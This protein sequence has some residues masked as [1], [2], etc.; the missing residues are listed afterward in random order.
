MVIGMDLVKRLNPACSNSYK[1]GYFY[2]TISIMP[3]RNII[4]V[5]P[6]YDSLS[7]DGAVDANI[8]YA[9]NEKSAFDHEPFDQLR[10]KRDE[11]LLVSK[12][13]RR[14]VLGLTDEVYGQIQIVPIYTLKAYHE[15]TYDIE[16]LK[17]NELRGILYF[18]KTEYNKESFAPLI[19]NQSVLAKNLK[20]LSVELSDEGH[21][22][23]DDHLTDFFRLYTK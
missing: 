17:R 16:K 22:I 18:P 2:E 6:L 1:K 13:K 21:N 9:K 15:K 14:R 7:Y 4:I 8:I 12:G 19:E 20:R 3:G 11:E 10:I 5:R 23:L